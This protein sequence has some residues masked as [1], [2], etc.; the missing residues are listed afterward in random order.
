MSRMAAGS[1]YRV[2]MLGCRTLVE[3]IERSETRLEL[4]K[5][6]KMFQYHHLVPP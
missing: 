2:D 6:E 3:M 1:S 5:S 4:L